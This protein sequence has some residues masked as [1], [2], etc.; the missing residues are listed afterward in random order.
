MVITVIVLII[1]AGVGINLTLGENGILR[2][3][4]DSQ[5]LADEA[6]VKEKVETAVLEVQIEEVTESGRLTLQKLYETLESKDSNIT[7]NDYS[8]GDEQLTGTYNLNGEIYGFIIDSGFNVIIGEVEEPE[9]KA[10]SFGE[11]TWNYRRK[12]DKRKYSI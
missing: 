7:L 3:A 6:T 4:E 5:K 2:R 1:L 9:P 12:L 8:E 10:V 11:V